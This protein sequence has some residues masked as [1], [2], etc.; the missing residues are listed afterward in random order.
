LQFVTDIGFVHQNLQHTTCACA[1][2]T[3]TREK[4]DKT[5]QKS[6]P[7]TREKGENLTG[8]SHI[9]SHGFWPKTR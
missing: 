1:V 4:C 8:N 6:G 5:C 7:K 2:Q 9:V 3:P